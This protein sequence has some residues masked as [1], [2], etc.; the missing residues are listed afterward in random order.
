MQKPIKGKRLPTAC[1]PYVHLSTASIEVM[2][3]QYIKTIKKIKSVA[4]SSQGSHT[5]QLDFCNFLF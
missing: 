3:G 2:C 5:N 4:Y 1:Q